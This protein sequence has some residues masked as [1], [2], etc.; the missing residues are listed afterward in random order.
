M[1]N[2]EK[3]GLYEHNIRSYEKVKQQFKKDNIAAIVHATGTGKSFNALQLALENKNKKIIYV[4]PYGSIIEHEKELIEKNNNV[5]LENDFPNLE[6]RTYQSFINMSKE[7][8]SKLEV[9]LLILDEFHHIGAPIWGQRI[10]TLVE[11]HEDLQIFGMTAYT[12]RDRG[13]SYERD[14]INPDTDELF[15][16]KVV[17][18]YDLCDAMIDEVLPKPNYK[19][20]YVFL[21]KTCEY[22]ETKINSLN[23]NSKDYQELAPLLKD[24]KKRV[25]E[26]PGVGDIFKTYIKPDGKYIYFCPINPENSVNDM[27]TIISELKKWLKEMGLTEDNYEFYMTTSEMGEEGKKNRDAFYNDKDLNQNNVSNKLRIMLAINQYNEGVH[28]PRLD[29]VIMARSTKSDIIFF[30]QLG[31]AL[32]AG[33]DN[34]K[35]HE[36]LMHKTKE[37]LI[38]ECKKKELTYSSLMSKEELIEILLAP[39]IIDLSGNIGF[40]K[41]L[42]N[43]LK[44]RM[45]EYQI[46]GDGEKRE[47]HLK[48]ASFDIDMINEDL[49]K[50][51]E[52]MRDRLTMT[53]MDKYELA[54]KYYEHYGNLEVPYNFKTTNGYEYDENGIKLGRWIAN[55]RNAYN[56]QG[57]HKITED[58]IK[59]LE[60]IGMRFETNKLE[61]EWNKKYKL[62]KKYYEHHGNLEIPQKFKTKNGYEYDENGITLG[63]WICTQRSAYNGQGKRKITEDQIN[64]LNKIGMRFET[65]KLEEEWNKKYELAKKYY[66]HYENLEVPRDFKTKNGYEYDEN[67]ITLGL[68]VANQ[69]QAYNGRGTCKI[70]ED[71]IKLL[72]QIGMRFEMRNNEEEW[73]KKYELSKKYYEHHG[74]LE[75]P[76]NFK[77]TNGYEYDENGIMLGLWVANQRQAYNGQGNRKI[78]EDQIKLLNQIGMR[79]FSRTIDIKFQKE[80]IYEKNIKRKKVELYNRFIEYLSKYKTNELPSKEEINEGFI[81]KLDMSLMKKE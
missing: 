1:S 58:Q 27:D 75:V 62:A 31:R 6:F 44:D 4:V 67:G 24:L 29:G 17:S 55:Q 8:I 30:E 18:N 13:T 60:K 9:D 41:D 49:F 37:E 48:N 65:N 64:L 57:T 28:I 51:I 70:T 35:E 32:S 79:W 80:I 36:A 2:Y 22:L 76:Y 78:T 61:E 53:W 5:S 16:N 74:N 11:T 50:I 42:E 47:I 43:N 33:K 71:Q 23:S 54:K 3:L 26:A 14:M 12:V 77:T 56:G 59:L 21:E 15:S 45:K 39:I 10:N 25:H 81:K 19:S 38:E 63:L 34:T 7:E 66:E 73:N 52:Y 72:N 20:G 69:R 46:S 40:I 68:W